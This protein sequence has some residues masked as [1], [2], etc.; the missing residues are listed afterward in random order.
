MML[1]LTGNNFFEKFRNKK[2]SEKGDNIA[3]GRWQRF[4]VG[5]DSR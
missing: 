2:I 3:M 5:I 1:Q 4:I